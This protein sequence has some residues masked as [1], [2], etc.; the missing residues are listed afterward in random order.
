MRAWFIYTALIFTLR[1]SLIG[2][3]CSLAEES[4]VQLPFVASGQPNFE[5]FVVCMEI[6]VGFYNWDG[7][8]NTSMP[9]RTPVNI[10]QPPGLITAGKVDSRGRLW[11]GEYSQESRIQRRKRSNDVSE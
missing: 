11:V 9:S 7:V 10:V 2:T 5:E 4:T 6:N 1:A 3:R 8:A